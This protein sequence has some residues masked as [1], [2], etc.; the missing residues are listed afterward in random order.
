MLDKIPTA[1]KDLRII[2][3]TAASMAAFL[4][5]DKDVFLEYNLHIISAIAILLLM[6]LIAL[7]KLI[8]ERQKVVTTELSLFR[9]E[10][11]DFALETRQQFVRGSIASMYHRYEDVDA[12]TSIKDRA[13]FVHLE[14]K[15]KELN[16]NSFTQDRVNTLRLKYER[17]TK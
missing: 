14:K 3:T 11:S 12:M 13:D 10:V 6:L 5:L 9:E 4:G 8:D 1:L 2:L 15:M 16:V 7:K 17:G